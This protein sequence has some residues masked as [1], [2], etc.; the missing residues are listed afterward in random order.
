VQADLTD[1]LGGHRSNHVHPSAGTAL[2]VQTAGA[3]R[4]LQGDVPSAV[5][6]EEATGWV[7][8]LIASQPATVEVPAAVIAP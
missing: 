1:S 7:R 6:V 5:E 3:A 2:V 4:H 8:V